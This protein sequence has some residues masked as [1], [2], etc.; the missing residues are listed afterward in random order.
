MMHHGN[1]IKHKSY[2]FAKVGSTSW[3]L[4][5]LCC[6]FSPLNANYY[7][8]FTS[9][10]WISQPNK[11]VAV[12]LRHQQFY[13]RRK[14]FSDCKKCCFVSGREVDR[15]WSRKKTKKVTEKEKSFRFKEPEMRSVGVS[16]QM[17]VRWK[18]PTIK[19]GWAGWVRWWACRGT[20]WAR[21]HGSESRSCAQSRNQSSWAQL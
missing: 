5:H 13:F 10:S 12:F 6:C 4:I 3:T 14:S 19:P 1:R 20:S 2:F 7:F 9:H 16:L 17:W 18:K 11:I 15:H 8:S 21:S